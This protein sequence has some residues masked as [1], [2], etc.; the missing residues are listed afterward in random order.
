MHVEHDYVNNAGFHLGLKKIYKLT[1]TRMYLDV[2]KQTTHDCSQNKTRL[3]TDIPTTPTTT[4][5][6]T[7]PL[8]NTQ[9]RPLSP[10]QDM[11]DHA[12]PPTEEVMH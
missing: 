10:T 11:D 5:K 12:L 2:A 9:G 1:G 7:P 4:T 8:P 6:Q 3:T